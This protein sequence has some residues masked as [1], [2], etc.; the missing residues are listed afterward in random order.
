MLK[1]IT[2][3]NEGFETLK[4]LNENDLDYVF[5]SIDASVWTLK[6]QMRDSK[7]SNVNRETIQTQRERENSLKTEIRKKRVKLL[8]ELELI[9]SSNFFISLSIEIKTNY[10]IWKG[11]RRM[12]EIFF[13]RFSCSNFLF[14]SLHT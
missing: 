5:L 7:E 9:M 11:G 6:V 2:Y 1:H 14:K 13:S 3:I 8:K 12:Q 4:A 10:D